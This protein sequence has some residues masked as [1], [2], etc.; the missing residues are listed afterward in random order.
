MTVFLLWSL[1]T[2]YIKWTASRGQSASVYTKP[3]KTDT[4]IW[5]Y[6]GFKE[7]LF[8]FLSSLCAAFIQN[9]KKKKKTLLSSVKY[10][11]LFNSLKNKNKCT[12]PLCHFSTDT[13]VICP[14]AEQ[15]AYA[16]VMIFFQN[17]VWLGEMKA[18]KY[19][20]SDARANFAG[21]CANRAV[22]SRPS[23]TLNAFT[24]S[25]IHR[26]AVVWRAIQ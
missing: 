20:R 11:F 19:K 25:I 7:R 5:C 18:D 12:A 16:L 17:S 6:S 15:Q 9:I 26:E 8:S 3:K 13:S 1:A 2:I 14:E 10:S 24:G 21:H 22:T 23:D 4:F